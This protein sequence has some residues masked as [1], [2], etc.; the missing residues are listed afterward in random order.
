METPNP[1]PPIHDAIAE[2]DARI[3]TIAD[4]PEWV[5]ARARKIDLT[6][7]MRTAQ[8]ID[9]VMRHF[10]RTYGFAGV[11]SNN[12]H[13]N[14]TRT[15]VEAIRVPW[16]DT[17]GFVTL[18]NPRILKLSGK[19]F[20]SVEGCGSI[21]GETYVVERRSCISVCGYDLIK[22]YLELEY[23]IVV[24]ND[25]GGPVIASYRHKGWVVQHEMDHLEG[26]TIKDKGVSF[27]L[28]SLLK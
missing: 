26:V 3:A 21:P 28:S 1:M 5:Y 19:R 10:R 25:G 22:S 18:V 9:R 11:S 14:R 17:P 13:W 20:Q 7:N 23:D 16:P 24:M 12:I 27:D 15:P 6:G 2:W 4:H 8:E